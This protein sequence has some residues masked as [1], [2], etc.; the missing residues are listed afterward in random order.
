MPLYW[1]KFVKCFRQKHST[2]QSTSKRVFHLHMY[3]H[4]LR[5][6]W[7]W[8]KQH[9]KMCCA[10]TFSIS[11]RI[12]KKKRTKDVRMRQSKN[13]SNENIPY[14]DEDCLNTKIVPRPNGWALLVLVYLIVVT[15]NGW[16][17]LSRHW[18]ANWH[19][20]ISGWWWLI[21]LISIGYAI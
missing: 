18:M 16:S 4:I 17:F 20:C 5:R 12:Q 9:E 7:Y 13:E 14:Y 10:L 19:S 1:V 8:S 21:S 11:I 6:C 15:L 3:L 2:R